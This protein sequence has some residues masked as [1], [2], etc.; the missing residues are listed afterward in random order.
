MKVVVSENDIELGK[1]AASLTAQLLREAIE[2]KGSARLI[3]STGAS[4][5]TTLKA[6]VEE[7]LDWSRVE[8]FHLD[9]YVNLPSTH[10][11][12]FVKYLKERFVEKT[13]PLKAVHFVDTEGGTQAIIEKLTK[14]LA[15]SPVD[16]GLIGIGENAH[17]AF[18]DPPADFENP[19][20]YLVV[21]LDEDCRKQQLGEGWF[22]SLMDVPKQAVSMTVSQILKCRHIISAVPY[23]VKAQAIKKTLENDVTNRIPA[24]ALKTHPSVTV[25]VDRDS[26]S[27][28]DPAV[29][30]QY[31]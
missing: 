1:K 15:E 24:T 5:F 6:L 19:A 3:L 29:L 14:E 30:Q 23:E 27:R 18:N 10:P 4:Q 9:E 16:V 31:L 11:A 7:T 25:F 22:P 28:V 17:I 20:S 12:S 21:N 8:M 2:E 13:G 26:V